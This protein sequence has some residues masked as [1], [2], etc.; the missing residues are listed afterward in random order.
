MANKIANEIIYIFVF[1]IMTSVGGPEAST[2]S[3]PALG[4][5]EKF[6]SSKFKVIVRNHFIKWYRITS[7]FEIRV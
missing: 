2:G 6:K 1:R 4:F 7:I 3:H 5:R